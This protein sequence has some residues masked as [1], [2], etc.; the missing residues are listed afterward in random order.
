M[1]AKSAQKFL[2]FFSLAFFFCKV[3]ASNRLNLCGEIMSPY[4]IKSETNILSGIDIEI[5]KVIFNKIQ[6]NYDIEEMAWP[7]CEEGLKTGK[8]DGALGTSKNSAREQFLYYPKNISWSSEFVFFTTQEFKKNNPRVDYEKI[9]KNNLR[10][11]VI[12]K[13]SYHPSFWEALPWVDETKGIYNKQIEPSKNVET[14]LLKLSKRRI[15]L[16]PQDKQIGLSSIKKLNIGD[17]DYYE[18]ILFKKD[19][20]VV[21]SRYSQYSTEKYKTILDVVKEY[22]TEISIFKRTNQYKKLFLHN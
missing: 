4:F 18:N 17:L 12:E 15:D 20:Y 6:V 21:F 8:Y 10:V 9:A 19:Y 7:K 5:L 14:N 3:Q 13:N 22:D 1:L 16:Y 11:G 2:F